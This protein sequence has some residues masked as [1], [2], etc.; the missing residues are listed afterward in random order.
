MWHNST[1]SSITFVDFFAS[2]FVVQKFFL[3][4]VFFFPF[5]GFSNIPTNCYWTLVIVFTSPTS[6]LTFL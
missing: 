3:F 4:F 5:Y 6:F 2:N 1:I